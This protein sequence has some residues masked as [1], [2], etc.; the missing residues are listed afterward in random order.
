MICLCSNP[1]CEI[2]GCLQNIEEEIFEGEYEDDDDDDT[3]N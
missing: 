2:Y 3:L 1:I